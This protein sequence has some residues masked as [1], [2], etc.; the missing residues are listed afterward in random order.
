MRTLQGQT[1][2]TVWRDKR[3][4]APEVE[5]EWHDGERHG[6]GERL[7]GSSP[8][9]FGQIYQKPKFQISRS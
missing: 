6:S 7:K 3:S 2:A 5:A 8:A 9:F 4:V 1:F